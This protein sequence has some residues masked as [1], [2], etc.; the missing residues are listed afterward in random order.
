MINSN[1]VD[2]NAKKVKIPSIGWIKCV[3]H[4]EIPNDFKSIQVLC[5]ANK[6][7]VVF[8]CKIPTKP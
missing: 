7:F 5:E 2:T 6:W 1:I 4:R 8:G 3:F